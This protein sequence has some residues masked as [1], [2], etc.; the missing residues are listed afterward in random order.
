MESSE[1]PGRSHLEDGA[2]VAGASLVRRAVEV[3]VRNL[4][5][6]ADRIFS[7]RAGWVSREAKAIKA[8]Q[9]AVEFKFKHSSVKPGATVYDTT[10]LRGCAVEI[11]ISSLNQTKGGSY[12]IGTI[13][14]ICAKSMY[15]GQLALQGEFKKCAHAKLDTVSANASFAIEFTVAWRRGP[16][17]ERNGLLNLFCLEEVLEMV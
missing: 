15:R 7:V 6:L 17:S 16:G 9:G 3:C 12:A 1:L 4:H 8:G 11:A 5:Q 2:K 14:I 13:G 10:S